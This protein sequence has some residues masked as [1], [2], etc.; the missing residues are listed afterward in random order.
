MPPEVE[1]IV[2]SSVD[3]LSIGTTISQIIQAIAAAAA[4]IAAFMAVRAARDTIKEGQRDRKTS[5]NHTYYTNLIVAPVFDALNTFKG[6]ATT[7]FSEGCKVFTT[8]KEQDVQSS[9]ID[10]HIQE[11]LD[12]FT[13]VYQ[14]LGLS[15]FSGVD[16]WKDQTLKDSLNDQLGSLEDEAKELIMSLHKDGDSINYTHTIQE[17]VSELMKIIMDRDPGLVDEVP[18]KNPP[19]SYW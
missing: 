2:K 11:L 12:N 13:D 1:P 18:I 3:W 19:E 16:A 14:K 10:A 15:I 4:A 7:L 5:L 17:N 8:L 6:Q 9:K